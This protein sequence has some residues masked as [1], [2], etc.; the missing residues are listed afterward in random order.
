MTDYQKERQRGYDRADHVLSDSRYAHAE[1]EC[2]KAEA[3]LV[4]GEAQ[5]SRARGEQLRWLKAMR[6]HHGP[7]GTGT[8]T[9]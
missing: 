9:R 3:A 5:I 6:W 7:A 1:L 4:R 8:G 2:S